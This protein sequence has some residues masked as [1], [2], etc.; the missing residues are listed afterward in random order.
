[1]ELTLLTVPACPNAGRVQERLATMLAE[2]LPDAGA[3]GL[4]LP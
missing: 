4:H 1:M 3:T 2:H